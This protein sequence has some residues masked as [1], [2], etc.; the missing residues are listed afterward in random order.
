LEMFEEISEN[1][2]DFKKFCDQF[3]K[4]LK[5]GIHEDS[6]NRK[7]LAELL[8]YPS[9][10]SG[11]ETTSL[12]DYVTRM[13]ENQKEIYYITGENQKQLE[14]S[15]FIEQC[16]KRG[17][18]VLYMCDPID[19]YAM[20]QLKDFEDKKFVCVT[21]EG[22]K[23]DETDDEKKKAEEEKT[24]FENLCKLI[25]EILGDKIEKVQLSRRIVNS[26][27]I[28][29]TGEYGWSANMERIM[30]AQALRDS[31]TSSYMA[32]KKT[33]EINPGHSIIK[34]LKKK[35]DE[36]RTDKTV[37]DLVWL[38]FDCSLLV[39]GF[40]LDDP[41]GFCERIHRMIKLGLSI[42]ADDA[43]DAPID[44]PE[45]GDDAGESKMEEVD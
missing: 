8:R 3:G 12:K 21:K 36:D 40:S 39:S 44:E 16:K 4:N 45:A 26:P 29:V 2:D 35:A 13:K 19:E 5:L 14:S 23:F 32:S 33:M 22:L 17:Y 7:K 11:E 20:Q 27:C 9:T 41:S 34:E 37:K 1:K 18:E 43:D 6:Q 24:A 15:P 30:K 28:L 42:D 31:S 25:K 10:K 38:L